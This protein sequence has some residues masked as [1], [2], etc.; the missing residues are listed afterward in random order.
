M[1]LS[2]SASVIIARLYGAEMV[3]VVAMIQAF[4]TF[5]TIFTVL[6]MNTS[7]LRLIP[8]HVARYS[9]S[10]AFYVYR[11]TQY[12]VAGLSILVGLILFYCSDLVATRIFSKPQLA[13]YFLLAACFVIFRSLL[14][15]NTQALRGIRLIRSFAFMQVLPSATLFFTVLLFTFFYGGVNSPVY[16]QLTAIAITSIVGILLMNRYFTKTM[17]VGDTVHSLPMREILG[18][19]TPMMMTASMGFVIGQTGVILL[20]M[21]GSA[22]D[23]GYYA[24]AVKLATLTAFVL[25]AINSMAAPKFSELYHRGDMEE[26]FYI[27]RKSTKLIFWTTAP[28]LILLLTLGAPILNLFFGSEFS[29]AYPA[30][31]ILVLGQFVSSISGSTG[32]FMNMTG[33]E[34][35]LRNLMCISAVIH[36]GLTWLLV[37]RY[38][39]SGAAC[40]ATVCLVLWNVGALIFIRRKF[41]RNFAYFPFWVK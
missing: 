17:K 27:A 28:V 33:H 1:F 7:M 2:L 37:P 36:I 16:A 20:G 12:F 13:T 26:L 29:V 19:S 5:T 6:G 18:I 39:I 14:E 41:Q 35:I 8:E 4:Y 25:K 11:K 3:G 32:H 31:A 23:V 34:K 38:G 10:S 24:V 9:I 21:F 22:A 15:L 30:M 40:A